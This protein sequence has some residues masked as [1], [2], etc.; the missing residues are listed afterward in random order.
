MCLKCKLSF[1][2]TLAFVRSSR[3]LIRHRSGVRVRAAVTQRRRVPRLRS[4]LYNSTLTII[5]GIKNTML[6][7]VRGALGEPLRFDRFVIPRLK[8]YAVLFDGRPLQT[9]N[10]L[11]IFRTPAGIII[12]AHVCVCIYI[13]IYICVYICVCVCVYACVR[14]YA[15]TRIHARAG[16]T[17]ARSR[18]RCNATRRDE[19]IALSCPSRCA[20]LFLP[21]LPSPSS[22][23]LFFLAQS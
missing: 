13:Y 2:S 10:S 3:G 12:L 18:A 1:S 4:P 19:Q 20:P 9:M 22:H 16:H 14:V 23:P 15:C 8:A 11:A 7:S 6:I 17:Y 21:F 5:P